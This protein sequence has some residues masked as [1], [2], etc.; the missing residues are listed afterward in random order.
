MAG[1]RIAFG[2]FS[3]DPSARALWRE[4]TS[5][6]LGSR[7]AALLAALLAANG[8]VVAH[9]ALLAAGWNGAIVEDSNLA[10][11]IAGLRRILG[12]RDDGGEWVAT[13]PRMGY[14][15]VR[16]AP[17]QPSGKPKLA[18]LPFINM[19]SDP[20]QEHVADGMVEDLITMF[21]RFKNLAV[22]ARHSAF[23]YKNRQFDIRDAAREL[24]ARYLIEGSVRRA[25]DRVRVTAQLIDGVSGEHIWAE[26]LDG[27]MDDVFD[28]QDRVTSGVIGLIEP[29]IRTA[30]IERARRKHPHSL[31][32]Y[33][34]YWRAT[35]MLQS[36]HGRQYS[37]A[38]E[39][40]DRA[41]QLEPGFGPILGLAAYAHNKRNSWGFSPPGVDDRAIGRALTQRA[42]EADSNDPFVLLAAAGDAYRDGEGDL[43]AAL[44]LSRRAYA[45]N[46]NSP[47]IGNTTGWFEWVAGNY[48]AALACK[49]QALELSPGAPERFWSLSGLAR[50][51]LSAGRV[52]EALVWALRAIE[53]NAEFSEPH[54]IAIAC[55]MALGQTDEARRALADFKA[56]IPQETIEGLLSDTRPAH[57]TVL[58]QGLT[59]ASRLP[60]A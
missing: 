30:E 60:P 35:P 53:A 50:T 47:V 13:V 19:T 52:E 51:H 5:V 54:G 44:A 56:A 57:D 45:L 43:D 3:Y 48:D 9:E 36:A 23:V 58:I 34:L 25:A 46:P 29:R 11:Q 2:P 24:G 10:V 55:Y 59:D 42:M 21:S 15:L 39:L 28:F 8:E 16:D 20:D 6:P 18:V 32:A 40:L 33:D 4:G 7:A 26:M 38:V 41:V 37:E 22:I 27:K 31:D 12:P 1:Q 17:E 14:R 49:L